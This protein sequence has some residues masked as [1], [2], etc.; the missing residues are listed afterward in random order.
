MEPGKDC[1]RGLLH[2]KIWEKK[3]SKYGHFGNS[4]TTMSVGGDNSK[5]NLRGRHTITTLQTFPMQN[6]ALDRR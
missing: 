6:T 4:S 1:A 5:K 3:C 2:S